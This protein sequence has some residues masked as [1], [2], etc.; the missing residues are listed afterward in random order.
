V[1]S[2]AI[3]L[4]HLKKHDNLQDA[5]A[6]IREVLDSGKAMSHFESAKD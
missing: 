2:G 4:W 5:A 6:Q 3:A 1:Y